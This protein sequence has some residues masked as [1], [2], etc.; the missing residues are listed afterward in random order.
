MKANKQ[1]KK[2]EQRI[3]EYFAAPCV[4]VPMK[5]K[6]TRAIGSLYFI[7]I[8][9]VPGTAESKIRRHLED[10]RQV[11]RLQLLQVHPEGM[12]LFFVASEDN[13]FD[14]RLF[15]IL[16]SPF[17]PEYTKDM[18]IPFPVG[19]NAMR[20]PIIVD[21]AQ[22]FSCLLAEEGGSGKTTNLQCLVASI[23]WSRS[24]EQVNLIIIDEP[25]NMTQFANLPHLVCPVI[26]DAQA[27]YKMIMRLHAEM[28]RRHKLKEE[29]PEE[30]NRLPKLVC[31]IDEC[32]SFV[33]G[34]SD[35]RAS[36]SLATT[37]SLI[38]RMGR[39][40]G[41]Y[42]VLATQNPALDEMKCDLKSVSSRIA[43]KFSRHQDSVAIL[44]ESGAEKL[45][46]IGDMYFKSQHHSGLM[47]LK[48]A[49][50]EK[51]EI[52]AVCDHIRTKY[53]E[54]GW[55]DTYKFIVD[56]NKPV[57]NIGDSSF[58]R[59]TATAQ[60]IEDALFAKIILWSLERE[61]V[62][63]NAI[64]IAFDDVSE[65]EAKKFIERLYSLGV[66]GE[67]K[68]K[69]GRKV[70]VTCVEDLPDEV[71][72]FLDRYIYNEGADVSHELVQSECEPSVEYTAESTEDTES[73]TNKICP[74]CGQSIA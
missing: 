5:L 18:A 7:K 3:A 46:G 67:P 65:R 13:V 12:D 55:D 4:N 11:L 45:P 66:A 2:Y 30:F 14:N 31:L 53:E 74:T 23:L 51:E 58:T 42:L 34:I 56:L 61:T 24:P 29:N 64:S 49:L 1:G 68:G 36:Q 50:I 57:E 62:S 20:T 16:T 41:I 70:L 17:Y 43:F 72:T 6:F 38:L 47:Y 54:T 73:A 59:P 32:V 63:A 27:G 9:F 35:N 48:G 21:L 8:K 52:A 39:H 26:Y 15:G 69:L 71:R 22:Y 40:A 28:K 25:A 37:I 33:S 60:E 44:N 10:A 19:F